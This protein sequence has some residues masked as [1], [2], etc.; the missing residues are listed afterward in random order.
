MTNEKRKIEELWTEVFRSYCFISNKLFGTA[1][2]PVG[3][4]TVIPQSNNSYVKSVV[5]IYLPLFQSKIV[6]RR[7][8][9]EFIPGIDPEI[10]SQRIQE[11]S[12]NEMSFISKSIMNEVEM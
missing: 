3:I 4:Y 2:N 1:L 8:L 10:E 12:E 6:S 11:E 7:T 5:D 9:Q